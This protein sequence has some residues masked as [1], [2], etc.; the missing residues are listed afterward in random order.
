[1][2]AYY[3][4]FKAFCESVTAPFNIPWWTVPLGIVVVLAV[5]F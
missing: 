1:M 3:E 4:S 2:Q 5:I